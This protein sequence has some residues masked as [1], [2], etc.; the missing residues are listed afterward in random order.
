MKHNFFSVNFQQ[1]ISLSLSQKPEEL[2][3]GLEVNASHLCFAE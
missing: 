2:H 1:L 3:S